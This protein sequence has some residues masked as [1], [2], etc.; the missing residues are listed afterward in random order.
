MTLC[1]IS[2]QTGNGKLTV[3]DAEDGWFVRV[4]NMKTY[5]EDPNFERAVIHPD[6]PLVFFNISG[7]PGA[8]CLPWEHEP[9]SNG[10]PCPNPRVVIPAE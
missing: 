7:L 2:L 6:E 8:T 4:D 1:H 5:G 3:A 9:D 10:K